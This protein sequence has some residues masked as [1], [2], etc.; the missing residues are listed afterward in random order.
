MVQDSA[1]RYG[2]PVRCP[3]PCIWPMTFIQVDRVEQVCVLLRR[4]RRPLRCRA[5]KEFC[6]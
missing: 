3:Y 4:E 2:R 5:V 6:S 1:L